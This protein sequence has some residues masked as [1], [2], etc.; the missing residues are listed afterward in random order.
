MPVPFSSIRPRRRAA[1]EPLEPRVLLHAGDLDLTFGT[2]GRVTTALPANRF[3]SPDVVIV[4]AG[5][6]LVAGGV[7]ASYDEIEI[8]RFNL[9]GGVDTTFGAGGSNRAIGVFESPLAISVQASGKILVLCGG[10]TYPEPSNEFASSNQIV[11][12][13]S[14]GSVDRGFGVNGVLDLPEAIAN[15]DAIAA[16]RDD[17]FVIAGVGGEPYPNDSQ[18]LLVARFNADGSADTSFGTEG[19]RHDAFEAPSE[20]G[21]GSIGYAVAVQS[22]G[23]VVVAGEA[24]SY[25]DSEQFATTDRFLV[26]RYDP[27]GNL[28]K[29]FNGKGSEFIDFAGFG[30]VAR[31]VGVTSSGKILV[32]GTAFRAF[33]SDRGDNYDEPAL[34][35]LNANGQLDTSFGAKGKVTITPPNFDYGDIEHLYLTAAG[36]LVVGESPALAR[37][38]SDGTLDPTFGKGGEVMSLPLSVYPTTL[39]APRPAGGIVAV[40]T[41]S[42]V[43]PTMFGLTVSGSVDGR[44]GENGR[45]IINS[46]NPDAAGEVTR[47]RPQPDGK[48]LALVNYVGADYQQ[49]TGFLRYRSDGTLDPTFG[50]NGFVSVGSVNGVD[51]GVNDFALTPNAKILVLGF[52]STGNK[53]S[54][55]ALVRL[56]ADGSVDKTFGA[57]GL[58]EI[59]PIGAEIIDGLSMAISPWGGID[60]ASAANP[61]DAL[62]TVEQL[63][64]DGTPDLSFG[65]GGE[66]D[67]SVP[68]DF[69]YVSQVAV[70]PDDRVVIA[71]ADHYPQYDTGSGLFVVIQLTPKGKPDPSFGTNGVVLTS[72]GQSSPTVANALALLPNGNL[73]VAGTN[74]NGLGGTGVALAE[75]D[76]AGRLVPSFGDGGKVVTSFGQIESAASVA[77]AADG[78]ILVGGSITTGHAGGGPHDFLL[79]RYNANG[80]L[81]QSFGFAGKVTT[82]FTGGD[83]T[84]GGI[85]I[86]PN[87]DIIAAGGTVHPTDNPEEPKSDVA[88][89]RYIGSATPPSGSISGV[90]F[91]DQ[92]ADGVREAAEPGLA[93]WVVYLDLNANG[94]FDGDE[95]TV[96]TGASGRFVFNDLPAGTYHIGERRLS[97]WRR[98]APAA[99]EL[100]VK[101]S[102]GQHVTGQN[103][104]NVKIGAKL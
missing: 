6:I 94:T 25:I 86:L 79:L 77:V 30:G 21:G 81:D 35:R 17:K 89:A 61:D 46:V 24:F 102:G 65:N 43:G 80:S 87:G 57:N 42:L 82:D 56:N 68:L 70:R 58:D 45:A 104:A 33:D 8:H 44:F 71:G 52:V 29:T 74:D 50:T 14:D 91:N 96:T 4:N 92:S 41:G 1:I 93:G 7:G 85:A 3:F 83:D 40:N 55:A 37:F 54:A 22:D 97:G 10:P 100:I 2:A 5:H 59:L 18:E 66:A 53:S 101:L 32:G 51:F 48:L 36:V 31:S 27:A 34:A 47:L 11:C 13:N 75:Y 60:L 76:R 73:I 15:A 103:F 78:K 99:G 63:N 88:I 39:I 95:P 69:V 26:A 28:D 12:F 23:K 16:A 84:V 38:R 62:V 19:I 98:V 64:P 9:D 90:V 72:F 67:I 20:F 49:T